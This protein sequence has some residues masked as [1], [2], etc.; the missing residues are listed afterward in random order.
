MK[1]SIIAWLVFFGGYSL[2]MAI[3]YWLRVQD[4]NITTS[5]IPEPLWFLI[6]ITLAIFA[7]WLVFI[8]TKPLITPWKRLLVLALHASAGIIIYAF[9]SLFY[10][11]GT[12]IDSL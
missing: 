12:G 10:I 11:V 9:S 8:A 3:D 7:L 4:N 6:P 5:G 1:K 2:E